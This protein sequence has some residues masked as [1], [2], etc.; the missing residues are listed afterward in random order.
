MKGSLTTSLMPLSLYI[1]RS[2]THPGRSYVGIAR[3]P[4]RRLRQ[5]NG[6]L[7]GGAKYT[8]A[9]RPWALVVIVSGFP[10]NTE[11]RCLE[12]RMHHTRGKKSGWVARVQLLKALLSGSRPITRNCPTRPSSWGELT[13]ETFPCSE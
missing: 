5:H 8:R 9:F 7:A 10:S 2:L 4:H 6:E 12:W 11:C 13:L 1:L 3:H